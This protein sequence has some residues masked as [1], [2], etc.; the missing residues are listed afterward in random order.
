MKFRIP[1]RALALIGSTLFVCSS[2]SAG[3]T[4]WVPP[5]ACNTLNCASMRLNANVTSSASLNGM[6]PFVVQL[7]ASP[8]HCTRFDVTSQTTDMEMVV[9]GPDGTV[10]RND[11]RAAGDVRPRVV[12]PANT[13]RTGW[14]TVQ[15][16]RY[17]GI[18]PVPG[19]HFDAVL[20]YGR[21]PAG[22]VNCDSP[23]TPTMTS[24]GPLEEKP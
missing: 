14:Y 7:M 16:S 5:G 20:E 9:V 15:I 13:G 22:N 6:E 19:N 2:A 10:W 23:T 11:D 24:A 1:C 18:P 17:N 4:M 12:I 8:S 21:Y 3:S